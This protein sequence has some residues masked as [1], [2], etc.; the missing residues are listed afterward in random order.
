MIN[1]IVTL[2]AATIAS[3]PLFSSDELKRVELLKSPERLV[4]VRKNDLQDYSAAQVSSILK[5]IRASEQK[6]L[7][8]KVNPKFWKKFDKYTDNKLRIKIMM[9]LILKDLYETEGE[10]NDRE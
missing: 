10:Q 8:Q 2:V 5:L 1:I 3:T 7:D 4:T 6:N 9:D